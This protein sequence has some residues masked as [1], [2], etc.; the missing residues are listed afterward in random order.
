MLTSVSLPQAQ[1]NTYFR[2]DYM[3]NKKQQSSQPSA[4]TPNEWTSFCDF[5]EI[6]HVAITGSN[7]CISTLDNHCMVRVLVYALYVKAAVHLFNW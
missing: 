7:V 3:R 1:A 6:T 2:N 4:N 5:P